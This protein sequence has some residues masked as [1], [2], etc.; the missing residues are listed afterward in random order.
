MQRTLKTKNYGPVIVWL[1]TG[2]FLVYCMVMVGGITR[3]TNSGLSM[4]EWTPAGSLPPL[5]E[6]EWQIQFEKYMQSPEFKI[7]NYN[8]DI[9]DFKKI[10]WWEFIHRMLGR[11]IGL[12]FTIPFLF[13][14][15]KKKFPE[16]FIGKAIILL[17]LG[18]MQGL[19][20]W[21]MVKSGL[22]KN[23][24]VSH[25]R[26]ALHLFTALM[27]FGYTFWLALDLIYPQREKIGG[28]TIKKMA[29]TFIILIIIQIIFGGFVAGLKAGYLYPTFPK[30][31]NEWVPRETFAFSPYW[32]IFTENHTGV[33]FIHRCIAFLIL[34]FCVIIFFM[35]KK[36]PLTSLQKRLLRSILLIVI[37]QFCLGIFTIIFHVPV[38]IAVLHQAGAFVLF[39]AAL[40]LI[41]R[42]R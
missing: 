42:I 33:Q 17:C 20:G 16:K 15:I 25:Y 19:V 28:G 9:S 6:K 10:F 5:S 24:H 40:F 11:A 38:V 30:M 8:F 34:F 21:F 29:A 3:L 39:G 18:T 7:I 41:H 13:F 36:A 22:V 1:L 26:L 27:L 31:G 4:V 35:S 23:P 14:W 32:K 2:C 12:V 37:L